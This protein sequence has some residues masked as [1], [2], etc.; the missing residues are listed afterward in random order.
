MLTPGR[1]V[2]AA[3]VEDDLPAPRPGVFYVYVIACEGGSFYIGHTD[4]IPR[5]WQEHVTGNAADWTKKHKPRYIPH[6]EEFNS[7]EEAVTREKELKTTSGRRWIKEAIAGGRARQAGGIPFEEKMSELSA[8]LYK[9]FA[10]A[11]Q[12]E[13]TIR[14]NLEVL[15]Y[16]K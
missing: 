15:G 16:G 5:R 9:Q 2:G 3:A 1:Y 7:R 8:K 11:D 14:K 6:Y 4:N 12:L 13:A 10:E